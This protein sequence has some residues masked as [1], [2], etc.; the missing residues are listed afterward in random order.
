MNSD[1]DSL[2]FCRLGRNS[3]INFKGENSGHSRDE[4]R[5]PGGE[6]QGRKETVAGHRSP[7]H[8]HRGTILVTGVLKG[9]GH[10]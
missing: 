6:T 4:R 3:L 9:G 2:G 5:T 8:T 10:S 7:V 1:I